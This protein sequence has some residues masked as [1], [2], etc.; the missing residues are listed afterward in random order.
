MGGIAI[1]FGYILGILLIL[2]FLNSYDIYHIMAALI[3]V[4]VISLIGI[5]DDL[6]ELRQAV[7]IILPLFAAIPLMI[8]EAGNT[9]MSILG[10][11]INFGYIYFLIL[12]PI[13]IMAASNLTNMLAGFNGL[14]T[15]LGIISSLTI[16]ILAL[17]HKKT[18]ILIILLPLLGSLLAFYIFNKYPAKIFPGDSGTLII[19]CVIAASVIV[20][21]FE[22]LGSY[23]MILYIINFLIYIIN[24]RSFRKNNWKFGYCDK[25]GYI[26]PPDKKCWGNVYYLLPKFFKLKEKSL[27]RLIFLIQIIICTII[28]FLTV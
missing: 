17:I 24:I 13:G 8:T 12:I 25:K 22:S 26:H 4:L 2:G 5:I 7:K 21:D 28:I 27:V 1:T 10:H 3:C 23:V 15:G 20:G 16:I 9:T 14:E 11:P 19:G 6:F 18:E